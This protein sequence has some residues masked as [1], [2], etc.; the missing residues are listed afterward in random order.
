MRV[1]GTAALMLMLTAPAFAQSSPQGAPPNDNPAAS[2][3]QDQQ[4]NDA[5]AA[6]GQQAQPSDTRNRQNQ[7]ELPATASPLALVG[8]VGL[9]ALGASATLRRVRS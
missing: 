1:F 7:A 5:D 9:L 8:L 4:R 6:P 2:T 3:P